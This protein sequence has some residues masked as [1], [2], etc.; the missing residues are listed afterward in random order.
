MAAQDASARRLIM[1]AA[2]AA[3]MADPLENPNFRRRWSGP[4]GL[5]RKRPAFVPTNNRAEFKAIITTAENTD[6]ARLF[7]RAN[8]LDRAADAALS[9][10]RHDTAERLSQLA[11]MLREVAL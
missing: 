8:R 6:L 5:E 9:F 1:D 11:A 3:A 2:R 7:Q 10:G 4:P